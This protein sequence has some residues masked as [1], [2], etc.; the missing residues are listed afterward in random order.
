MPR[1]GHLGVRGWSSFGG[2]GEEGKNAIEARNLVD[3]S[4]Y[5]Y[6]LSSS[7]KIDASETTPRFGHF[8]PQ[9]P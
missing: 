4:E 8:Q 1:F 2:T 9:C 7:L 5:R 6:H 3:E